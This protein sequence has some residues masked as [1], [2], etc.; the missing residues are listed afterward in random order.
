MSLL[1]NTS[2]LRLFFGLGSIGQ[3][4]FIRHKLFSNML[5]CSHNI[6]T[7][8]AQHEQSKVIGVHDIYLYHSYYGNSHVIK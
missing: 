4:D 2:K 7:L 5:C 8:H 1:I 3:R 6:T